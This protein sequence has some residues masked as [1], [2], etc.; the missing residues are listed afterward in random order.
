M[1]CYVGHLPVSE[2]LGLCAPQESLITL[3]TSLGNFFSGNPLGNY[4]FSDILINKVK[5]LRPTVAL[6]LI[7]NRSAKHITD[8]VLI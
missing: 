6:R 1:P 5:I 4:T 7:L 2:R 3:R 8:A